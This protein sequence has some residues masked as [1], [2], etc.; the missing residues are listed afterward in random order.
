MDPT[1]TTRY[2]ALAL[3]CSSHIIHTYSALTT[4]HSILSVVLAQIR[5]EGIFTVK[6]AEET[7][8]ET[9][10]LDVIISLGGAWITAFSIDWDIDGYR[11]RDHLYFTHHQHS[12]NTTRATGLIR[13]HEREDCLVFLV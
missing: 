5:A 11:Y 4:P 8:R 7:E 2:F 3:S 9:Y 6:K 13:Y 12:D 1:W 10:Y